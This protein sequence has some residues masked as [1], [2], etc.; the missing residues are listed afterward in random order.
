MVNTNQEKR[1]RKISNPLTILALFAGIAETAGTI[2]LPFVSENLQKYFIWYVMGFPVL[3]VCLFFY[4]LIRFPNSLYAPSDYRNEENFI[5]MHQKQLNTTVALAAATIHGHE[6]C[7]KESSDIEKIP[8]IVVNAS[9]NLKV[10]SPNWNNQILWV[11]DRPE[12]N[13]YER[14]AFEAIGF[15]FTLALSTNQAHELLKT[16]SYIAI[17]SDMGRKEG[18][19]EGY[20]LLEGIRSKGITTPF[21]IYAGSNLPEHKKEA[22]DKGAQ[23]STCYADELFSLVTNEIIKR[24]K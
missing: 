19:R 3:L 4:V 6:G 5:R 24:S 20:V 17:I 14:K 8:N 15:E 23:G 21:F 12:N 13:I 16:N 18:E 11:D 10:D 22:K 7:S 9:S 1:V 2:V